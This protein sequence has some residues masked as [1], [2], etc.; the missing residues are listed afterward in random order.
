MVRPLEVR[1]RRCTRNETPPDLKIK[2][3]R[4]SESRTGPWTLDQGPD[5]NGRNDTDQSLVSE[6]T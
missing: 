4:T 3:Y 2:E 1:G 5:S 6:K